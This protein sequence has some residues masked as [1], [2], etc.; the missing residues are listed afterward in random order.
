MPEINQVSDIAAVGRSVF[1]SGERVDPN[2]HNLPEFDDGPVDVAVAGGIRA[3]AR[4]PH[5][6]R[7]RRDMR[8]AQDVG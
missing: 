8:P 3:V 7:G 4:T 2:C 6:V 5:G 1:L